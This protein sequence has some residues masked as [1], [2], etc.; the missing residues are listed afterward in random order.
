M[1]GALNVSRVFGHNQ[2]ITYAGAQDLRVG[3]LAKAGVE[4]ADAPA[5]EPLIQVQMVDDSV[6]SLPI[7]EDNLLLSLHF[8]PPTKQVL[9]TGNSE[10]IDIASDTFGDEADAGSVTAIGA[11]QVRIAHLSRVSI[12]FDVSKVDD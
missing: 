6:E 7:S 4:G 10:K 1:T 2:K 8:S 3:Q 5:G 9:F 11:D 12:S